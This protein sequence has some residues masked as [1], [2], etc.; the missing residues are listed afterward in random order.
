MDIHVHALGRELE[1]LSKE[2]VRL[3]QIVEEQARRLEAMQASESRLRTLTDLAP[4]TVW[5][6]GPDGETIHF[7]NTWREVTGL[8]AESSRSWGWA[9][10][11]HDHDREYCSRAYW[12]AV[13]RR[14]P[15][16]LKY[17]I[18]GHDGEYRWVLDQGNP[19]FDERGEF[20]DR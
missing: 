12:R 16:R 5:M 18:R 19:R 17:R 1:E 20:A 8:P 7:N 13:E 4:V 11:L 6:C 14:E 9:T 2:N 15:F 10:L 3:R